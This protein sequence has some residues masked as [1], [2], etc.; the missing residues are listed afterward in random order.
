VLVV[1]LAS[2]LERAQAR[3]AELEARLGRDSTKFLD[4]ALA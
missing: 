4:P 1:G 3:I 2:E